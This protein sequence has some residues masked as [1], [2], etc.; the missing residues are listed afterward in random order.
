MGKIILVTSRCFSV[1][2]FLQRDKGK[3]PVPDDTLT[4]IQ[5]HRLSKTEAIVIV[6]KNKQVVTY[7]TS[8]NYVCIL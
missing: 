5:R 8:M 3:V 1:P 7:D 4:F 6:G 2:R